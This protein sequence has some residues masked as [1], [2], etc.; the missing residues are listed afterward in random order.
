MIVDEEYSL[1]IH[2]VH[3]T[4]TSEIVIGYIWLI[5]KY[6]ENSYRWCIACADA[7]RE[8]HYMC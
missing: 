3:P 8:V 5:M 1:S 7:N 6:K 2:K 4:N